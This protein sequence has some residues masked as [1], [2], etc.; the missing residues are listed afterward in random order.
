MIDAV[1]VLGLTGTIAGAGL[2]IASK[3]FSVEKDERIEK[4]LEIL[5]SANCGGCGFPGC[6]AFADALVKGE[7][8]VNGCPVGGN[9]VAKNVAE[10]LGLEF[11]NTVKKVARVRCNGGY[12]NCSEKYI[13]EGPGD[14]HSIVM[15]AGG[16]K[17]CIYGCVGGGSCVTACKFDAIYIGTEGIPVVD[18]EKCTSCGACVSACPRKLIELLPIDKK[19]T[20]TCRSLDKGADAKNFCKVACIAC[21]LCQK[22]CPVEA[23]TVE[24]NVAY[25]DPTKCINC[26]KCKEVCPTKAINEF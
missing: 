23:I 11:E 7:A 15:L 14:C 20:V 8:K 22:N 2:L 9:E 24:N 10:I 13:Y 3:K 4:L 1:V 17:Q 5:P 18:Q 16:I 26:G 6:A 19:F 21:K 12:S 25:I